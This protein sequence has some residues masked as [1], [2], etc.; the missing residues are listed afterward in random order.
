M[1]APKNA[2]PRD[3]EGRYR[4]MV[5]DDSAVIRGF[6]RRALESDPTI[7]VVASVG[8]GAALAAGLLTWLFERSLTSRAAIEA[9][10][11]DRLRTGL[12]SAAAVAAL[13][14][15]RAGA[16]PPD[17]SSVRAFLTA[18]GSSS[19]QMAGSAGEQRRRGR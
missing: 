5:V 16:D 1:I 6:F 4:V 14:C 3:A 10:S 17:A 18:Q 7:E 2:A 15:T 13:D 19:V 12:R 11:P 8:A 9:L